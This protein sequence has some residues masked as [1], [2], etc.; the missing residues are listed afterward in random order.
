MNTIKYLNGGWSNPGNF[1]PLGDNT[2]IF[3]TFM[4]SMNQNIPADVEKD[5]VPDKVLDSVE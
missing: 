3:R 5:Y 1:A 4:S 2:P